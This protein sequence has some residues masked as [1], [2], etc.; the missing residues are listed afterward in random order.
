M[1]SISRWRLGM[2]EP[3]SP[4]RSGPPKTPGAL[5]DGRIGGSACFLAGLSAIRCAVMR[6]LCLGCVLGIAVLADEGLRAETRR[7]DGATTGEEI[8]QLDISVETMDRDALIYLDGKFI[9]VNRQSKPV[10]FGIHHLRVNCEGFLPYSQEIDVRSKIQKV[11]IRAGQLAPIRTYS[12]TSDYFR[13]DREV[14]KV[15]V[16]SQP[17]GLQ[18]QI[19]GNRRE[20]SSLLS[21]VPAGEVKLSIDGQDVMVPVF[22]GVQTTVEYIR[23]ESRFEITRPEDVRKQLIEE[24]TDRFRHN[25]KMPNVNVLK[26]VWKDLKTI[27]TSRGDLEGLSEEAY[28]Q[29]KQK[30]KSDDIKDGLVLTQFAFEDLKGF[31]DK[32]DLNRLGDMAAKRIVTEIESTDDMRRV[33]NAVSVFPEALHMRT[34]ERPVVRLRKALIKRAIDR[35]G[36]K[37]VD[38]E[39]ALLIRTAMITVYGALNDGEAEVF[40][41]KLKRSLADKL[42]TAADERHAAMDQLQEALPIFEDQ[43]PSEIA[44]ALKERMIQDIQQREATWI[45]ATM[46]YLDES[47]ELLSSFG[48]AVIRSCE[49]SDDIEA[50]NLWLNEVTYASRSLRPYAELT[51]AFAVKRIKGSEKALAYFDRLV[52]EYGG[53]E[54]GRIATE[55]AKTITFWRDFSFARLYFFICLAG[56]GIVFLYYFI[57]DRKKRKQRWIN[58][59]SSAK[60]YAI[61]YLRMLKRSIWPP[62]LMAD[63]EDIELFNKISFAATNV[64]IYALIH[65]Y[66]NPQNGL[67]ELMTGLYTATGYVALSTGLFAFVRITVW[68]QFGMGQIQTLTAAASLVLLGFWIPL[69][70]WLVLCLWWGILCFSMF[71]RKRVRESDTTPGKLEDSNSPVAP[72]E[73]N[74]EKPNEKNVQE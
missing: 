45:P 58:L 50:V 41:E 32:G 33:L 2:Q 44:V 21:N 67:M 23:D 18:A 13:M 15:L 28:A 49:S 52:A 25:L 30:L 66:L 8:A 62:S 36:S 6:A 47:E 29:A 71:I 63:E 22:A 46:R 20:T 42:D 56:G 74:T 70:G 24:F 12:G 65:G 51:A 73:G 59:W 27:N 64:A 31:I 48:K 55:E 16:I 69:G 53:T 37:P 39:E 5:I 4:R 9:G 40:S 14:G 68:K 3:A 57:L 11:H 19:A 7:P 61:G 34:D 54:V 60:R 43:V 1:T 10:V 17:P 26:V 72:N 35:L 38:I